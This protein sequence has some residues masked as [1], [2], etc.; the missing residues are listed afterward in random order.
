M[1]PVL[2][3]DRV[4]WQATGVA[5]TFL[6]EDMPAKD[7]VNTSY[8]KLTIELNAVIDSLKSKPDTSDTGHWVGHQVDTV[9]TINVQGVP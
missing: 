5:N 4:S 6:W 3:Q 9:A 1:N 7:L 8:T 2:C